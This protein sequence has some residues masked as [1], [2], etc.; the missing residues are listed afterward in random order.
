MPEQDHYFLEGE[1]PAY[2]F[3]EA[4]FCQ[5][6]VENHKD[7]KDDKNEIDCYWVVSEE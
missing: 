6:R 1:E 4:T 2:D 3:F 5:K 7:V